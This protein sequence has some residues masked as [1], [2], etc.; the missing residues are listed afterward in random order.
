M[1]SL[2]Q[3]TLKVVYERLREQHPRA[4]VKVADLLLQ[5]TPHEWVEDN[6]DSFG[7]KM[8]LI[9]EVRSKFGVNLKKANS[10]VSEHWHHPRDE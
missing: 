3:Q 6:L 7:E 8:P 1:N 10:I 5:K 2:D 9:K 4:A